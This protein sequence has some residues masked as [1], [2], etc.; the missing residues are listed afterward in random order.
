MQESFA[1]FI[2]FV[3]RVEITCTGSG[4]PP[5]AT[6]SVMSATLGLADFAR[7]LQEVS[8]SP[9]P[10]PTQ[11]NCLWADPLDGYTF[12]YSRPAALE[13]VHVFGDDW[14]SECQKACEKSALHAFYKLH[15]YVNGED[16]ITT[17]EVQRFRASASEPYCQG[18]VLVEP[19]WW[20]AP[21][22]RP[23]PLPGVPAEAPEALNKKT[24]FPWC[25]VYG[26]THQS[27]DDSKPPLACDDPKRTSPCESLWDGT[28]TE[29][30]ED[31][32]GKGETKGTSEEKSRGTGKGK[33]EGESKGKGETKG[34]SEEKSKGKDK[35]KGEG[36]SG[37]FKHLG[38]GEFASYDELAL[39]IQNVSAGMP[40]SCR[41]MVTTISL[42][43]CRKT[44]DPQFQN[45][46]RTEWWRDKAGNASHQQSIAGGDEFSNELDESELVAWIL[47]P[48]CVLLATVFGL[49]YR[50][51]S[52]RSANLRLSR[53][54]AQLDLQMLSHQVVKIVAGRDDDALSDSMLTDQKSKAQ[55]MRVAPLSTAGRSLPPG[56]P[57]SSNGQS[58]AEQDQSSEAEGARGSEA[59]KRVYVL[60]EVPLSW[61]EADRQFYASAAGKAYLANLAK[62]NEAASQGKQAVPLGRTTHGQPTA[63]TTAASTTALDASAAAAAAA[64]A[65]FETS[66]GSSSSFNSS[67][68]SSAPATA[69]TPSAALGKRTRQAA[70][71]AEALADLSAQET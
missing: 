43:G 17:D 69:P 51:Y 32:K 71:A 4:A 23:N 44:P 29:S 59:K 65:E 56:P 37:G 41:A 20:S 66:A 58:V 6:S 18:I 38:N 70:A 10:A 14:A 63:A 34:T 16:A 30:Q 35:G 67:S 53:D 36:E 15:E 1:F 57:S 62:M 12:A 60:D 2:C 8:S 42:L 52:R 9:P 46:N 24:P 50:H 45:R 68:A 49:L 3:P 61:A 22:C 27:M 28:K 48:L 26:A 39:K 47:L 7:A 40:A 55:S 31:F 5:H 11:E 21:A 54:R 33:G 64:T 25:Y 13:K 19:P